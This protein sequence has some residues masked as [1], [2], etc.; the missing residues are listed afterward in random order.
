MPRTVGQPPPAGWHDPQSVCCSAQKPCFTQDMP[1][2][3]I[4]PSL[5]RNMFC[6]MTG[7]FGFGFGIHCNCWLPMLQL[8]EP[9]AY[10]AY[11]T[12]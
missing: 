8:V 2:C 1:I 11:C 3:S 9:I 10:D 6:G 7:W 5:M 12:P 4:A